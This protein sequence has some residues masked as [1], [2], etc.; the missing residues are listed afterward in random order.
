MTTAP[1]LDQRLAF[2]RDWAHAS[3]FY[4]QL[5]ISVEELAEGQSVVRLDASDVHNNADGIVHGGVLPA[6]ADAAMGCA[7]RTVHGRAAQLLTVESNLRYVRPASGGVL[8]A[9]GR[10]LQAHR[11]VAFTEVEMADEEHRLLARGGATFLL[12]FE[13]TAP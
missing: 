6:L 13:D 3:P 12:R 5:R 4:E 1:D 10:V 8:R 7:L 9:Y 2:A 11:S